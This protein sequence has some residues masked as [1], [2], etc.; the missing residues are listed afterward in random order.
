M[1]KKLLLT[2]AIIAVL[3]GGYFQANAQQLTWP[4][5]EGN[6]GAICDWVIVYG[7]WTPVYGE[8]Q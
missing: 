6:D 5:C 2:F 1:K 4:V 3:I 7:K 8:W